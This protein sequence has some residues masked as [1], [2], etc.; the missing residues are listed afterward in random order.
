[1]TV[2]LNGNGFLSGATVKFGNAAAVS[3]NLNSDH[4]LTAVTPA[5]SA[6][7][8]DVTVINPDGASA[9]LAAGYTFMPPNQPPQVSPTA[10]VT[11][12]VA[13]LVVNFV[14]NATD[15]DGG[16]LN[17]NWEF[18]DGQT[19]AGANVLHTYMSAGQFTAHVTATDPT[20]ALASAS[21][22][23]TVAPD[24]RPAIRV[25]TPL[26]AQK[27]QV[28]S[29]VVI[30]WTANTDTLVNQIIELSLDGGQTWREVMTAISG[31][32]RSYNWRVPNLP[33]NAARIRVTATDRSGA[34]GEAMNPGNFTIGTKLK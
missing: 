11:N 33:T 10:S 31:D 29:T 20:G 22:N 2:N 27:A 26:T 12:G 17:V 24:P 9:T 34:Q 32:A 14:A 18:G 1:M 6:G 4:L 16:A 21:L 28:K 15:P 23:I 5:H 25:L 8:V 13:P 7:N 30:F 19:A 3:V